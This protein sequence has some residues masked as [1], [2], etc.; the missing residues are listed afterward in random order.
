[1][2]NSVYVVLIRWLSLSQPID[3]GASS[4]ASLVRRFWKKVWSLPV[5][6][7]TRHFVW[8]ACREALP[9]KVNL[10]RLKVVLD[11]T[12]DACGLMAKSTGHVLW[13]CAKAQ[14]VLSCSKLVG[15]SVQYE[16][17]SFMDLMWKMV[18][19]DWVKEEKVARMVTIVWAL[20]FN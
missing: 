2:V 12:C 5:P 8:R 14:E 7:K 17:F 19:I 20:W 6:H 4:D 9:T 11:N 1:M 16:C 3:R 15:L 13:D 10:A 18:I